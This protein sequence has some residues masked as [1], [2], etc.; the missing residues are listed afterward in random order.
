M[1]HFMALVITSSLDSSHSSVYVCLTVSSGPV[2]SE[3][4]DN[5]SVFWNIGDTTIVKWHHFNRARQ[6]WIVNAKIESAI[7]TETS[8]LK[9]VNY[10]CSYFV[11]MFYKNKTVLEFCFIWRIYRKTFKSQDSL[12]LV[13]SAILKMGA[14]II[15]YWIL[16]NRKPSKILLSVMLYFNVESGSSWFESN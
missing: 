15:S 11:R 8:Q 10:N 1:Y 16:I 9:S 2:L 13:W 6:C 7:Y 3:G 12:F 5:N 14:E 4:Q